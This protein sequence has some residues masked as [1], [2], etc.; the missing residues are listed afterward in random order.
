M[1][2]NIGSEAEEFAADYLK[3]I[4]FE[5]ID[6][7]WRNRFCEID[8][9]ARRG[10]SVHFVEVKYR[11][12]PIAGSSVEYITANKL[13]QM[14]FAALHWISENSWE[15][16]YQLDVIAID[17]SISLKHLNFIQAVS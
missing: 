10:N 12:T 5:I 1:P 11:A 16:D 7:N 8:I 3:K 15:G 6:R 4:G 9:V 17:G 2:A 14:Q 13:K